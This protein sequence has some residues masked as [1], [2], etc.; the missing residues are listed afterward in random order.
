MLGQVRRLRQLAERRQSNE[1]LDLVPSSHPRAQ[2]L[3]EKRETD[4]VDQPESQAEREVSL[5]PRLDLRR[6]GCRLDHDR[7]G[8]LNR[9]RGVEA[10]RTADVSWLYSGERS[11]PARPAST[12]SG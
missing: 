8:A 5:R 11:R 7:C 12:S 3:D 6:A 2:P 4:A 9:L 10:A 1:S